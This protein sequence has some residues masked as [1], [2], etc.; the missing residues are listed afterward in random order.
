MWASLSIV[1][2]FI[3][4]ASSRTCAALLWQ[5]AARSKSSRTCSSPSIDRPLDGGGLVAMRWPRYS[6]QIGSASET[7]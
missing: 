4:S 6:P 3:A 7:R 5:N 2:R 1:M